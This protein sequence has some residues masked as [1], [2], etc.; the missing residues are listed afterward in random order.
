MEA[1]I[2]KNLGVISKWPCHDLDQSVTSTCHEYG[3][4]D[5]YS[6]AEISTTTLCQLSATSYSVYS[7]VSSISWGTSL[8]SISTHHTMVTRVPLHMASLSKFIFLYILCYYCAYPYV[9]ECKY[10]RLYDCFSACVSP[11]VGWKKGP[12][13]VVVFGEYV[14]G[15][16]SAVR[17]SCRGLVSKNMFRNRNW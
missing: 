12:Y 7:Q 8:R 4:S 9:M 16:S 3:Q 1:S 17:M 13:C 15:F 6:S 14:I 2:P 10:S 11:Y 5:T